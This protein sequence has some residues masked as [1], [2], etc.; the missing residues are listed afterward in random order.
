MSLVHRIVNLFGRSQVDREIEAELQSH[1]ALR[2]EDNLAEGMSPAEARRYA[3]LRF[4]NRNTIQEQVAAADAAL[5]LDSIW[6]DLRYAL[7]QL[8]RSPGFAATAIVTLMLGIGANIV[9]FGVLNA[10]LL[11]PLDVS[12]PPSLYQIR[13]QAWTQGKLL[14]TSYPAFEDFQR[15]NSAF[16]GMAAVYGYSAAGLSW[17]EHVGMKVHGDEVTG[18][19][20]DL[21]GVQPEAGRIFHASDEHG[22][23]SAPYI[24]LSDALWQG[25]FLADPRIV[26]MTVQLN[27][28]PFTVIGVAPPQFHGTERFVWPDYWIPMA[29]EQQVEGWDYLHDRASIATTVIGRLKS[30]ITPEQA[31]DNLNAIAAE[32]AKEYP[33]SDEGLP[34]RLIHPG[35]FGDDAD[36]IRGFLWSVTALALLVLAAACTNLATLFAARA[37]DRGRELALRVALGSSRRRLVRQL[38]TEAVLIS[39]I[40]GAAGLAAAA[41]L[42][43]ALN[44]WPPAAEAHLAAGMD[45][46]VYIAGLALALASALLFGMIPARQ[47][48]RSNPLQMMKVGSVDSIHLCRFAIRDPLLGAQ[49]A[50]CTLLVT[51]SLVA[52]RGMEQALHTPL[53]FQPEGAMLV[54]FDLSYG[55]ETGD[56]ALEKEKAMLEAARSIPGVTTVGMVNRRPMN[57]GHGTP[58]YRAGT[59]DF[60]IGNAALA[61]YLF[62]ISPGFL[63]AAGTRLLS[64][65]DVSWTDTTKT[66]YVAIVNQ[67]FAKRMWGQAGS[68]EAAAIGQHFVLWGKP[69]EVI[70]VT[71]EG[72][73]RDLQ[74]SPQPAVYLPYSQ[75]DFS[76]AVLVVRSQRSSNEMTAS[77]QHT[78]GGIEP[79]VPLSI[80]SWPHALEDQLLPARAATVALG[81]LGLL[82]TML[83]VTGIFGMAAYNVSR[84]MRE[85]G[86]RV[87]LGA[88]WMHVM[89]AA[90]GRP[91]ALLIA[92]S[93]LGMTSGAFSTG[94]LGRLVYQA[95]PR[96]PWVLVAAVGTM[97]LLGVIATCVP[98]RRALRADPSKL[99]HEE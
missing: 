86:I 60:K 21:L 14:T 28:H 67:T 34:L 51:A 91:L 54:Q 98:A 90:V 37:A 16:S 81:V 82:A 83:A 42:L 23:N 2:I 69:T 62:S 26:G 59:T 50:I 4:G 76:D 29:N 74:E 68:S 48:W 31:T 72:K 13:H 36:V 41:L 27:K 97:A 33:A 22:P 87:A 63:D 95:D 3:L 35:L 89:G 40:G 25:A 58:I 77:L 96:D 15:R 46:R 24:V 49:I 93:V 9:V 45:A 19:Y 12:D 17:G 7:R 61:P 38:L 10:V 92:G 94:L 18:N 39:L 20:F 56:A 79:N 75:G 57:G 30:G 53:G 66:P 8:R 85:L 11:H 73:Y 70:G 1:I 88:Q 52:V 32:L 6:R 84:R 64:G 78:L 44:R 65:R 55:G 47:V 80:Q 5:T 43:F 99:M 71:E